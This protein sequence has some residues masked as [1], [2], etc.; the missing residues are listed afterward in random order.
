MSH[1]VAV[2]RASLAAKRLKERLDP[3]L[4]AYRVPTPEPVSQGQA[5]R[6]GIVGAGI[7]GLIA[8][9]LLDQ[10]GHEV[11]VFE[12]RD[13]VGGRIHTL[14]L[15]EDGSLPV[16]AGASRIPSN[17]THTLF[18]LRHLGIEI[19]AK[20]PERGRLVR[21]TGA[22]RQVGRDVAA[23]SQHA[24]HRA[25]SH[26]E[27]EDLT[28]RSVVPATLRLLT[29][30]LRK[31]GWYRVAGGAARLPEA[32]AAALNSPVR[33][34][35]PV[36]AID[37]RDD[38]VAVSSTAGTHLFDR[39]LVTVPVALY[40]R[41]SFTPELPDNKRTP[42]LEAQSQPSLRAFVV[43][44]GGGPVSE[45][46]NGWGSTDSGL[47]IWRFSSA[48]D[49]V[50]TIHVLYAQGEVARSLVALPPKERETHLL[51][52]FKKAFPW[53]EGHVEAVHSH[54]WNDDPWARGAQ[55]RH[56]HDSWDDLGATF[57]RVHF[58]GEGT[59][60]R[61]WI[62]G[63]IASAYRAVAEMTPMSP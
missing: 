53:A 61:G 3:R 58:A 52:I 38:G 14:D 62:D 24:V 11:T 39:V 45:D 32:V 54:C 43:T 9:R 59:A 17:H 27:E 63:T 7:S 37:Q 1:F 29:E 35:T 16:D 56:R 23:L 5:L 12:A 41:I 6:I 22:R 31:P 40:E 48:T 49:P 55:T 60:R 50:R 26:G 4:R 46:A 44:H 33:L 18:W 13:R 36:S 2:R 51:E 8:A 42:L 20:Y 34:E 10:A 15:L 30:T 25:I 28:E 47:E 57:G 21:L 19:E